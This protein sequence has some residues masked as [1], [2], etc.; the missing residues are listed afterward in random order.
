MPDPTKIPTH[1]RKTS[2]LVHI[3]A[4][5]ATLIYTLSEGATAKIKKIMLMNNTGVND[6]VIFGTNVGGVWVA[7]MPEIY[8]ITPFDE[9]LGEGEIPQI[10]FETD[11]YAQSAN[12]GAVTPLDVLIEVDEIR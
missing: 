1:V 5:A 12:A 8:V 10:I 4:A 7:M 6:L 9:Q 2:Q 11:I 3:V